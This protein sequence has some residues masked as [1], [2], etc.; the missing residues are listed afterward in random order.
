MVIAGYTD[1]HVTIAVS[2]DVARS[3]DREAGMG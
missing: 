2:V 1:Y 3:G